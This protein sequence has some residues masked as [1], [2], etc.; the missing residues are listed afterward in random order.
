VFLV[1][2]VVVAYLLALPL[3][4]PVG[5][6]ATAALS[7]LPIVLTASIFGARDG[8]ATAVASSRS[9]RCCSSS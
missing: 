4:Y 8:V 5:G 1:L 7:F 2:A 9:I 6:E 3:V